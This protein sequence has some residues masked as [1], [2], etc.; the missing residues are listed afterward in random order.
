MCYKKL[1]HYLWGL[2]RAASV[3]NS[4]LFSSIKSEAASSKMNVAIHFAF[5]TKLKTVKCHVTQQLDQKLVNVFLCS[6]VPVLKIC[7]F[8][9]T[10]DTR[11]AIANL[12]V[13]RI[14]SWSSPFILELSKPAVDLTVPL[15]LLDHISRVQHS[16][17]SNY[18]HHHMLLPLWM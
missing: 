17:V 4:P 12:Q 11:L 9:T 18:T 5:H 1:F 16:L 14:L 13:K 10:V 15:R 3:L 6:D 2:Q 8:S 7:P